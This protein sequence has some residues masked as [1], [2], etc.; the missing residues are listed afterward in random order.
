MIYAFH[1]VEIQFVC[2][3]GVIWSEMH[4]PYCMSPVLR[5]KIRNKPNWET[6]E[7]IELDFKKHEVRTVKI[8]LDALYG[9]GEEDLDTEDLVKLVRLVDEHGSQKERD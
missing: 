1:K 2:L 4:V 5:M 6:A 8:F 9:C 7:T 3:D